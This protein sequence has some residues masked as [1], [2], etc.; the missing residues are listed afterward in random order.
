MNSYFASVEQQAN[1]FLRERVIGVCAYNNPASTIIASS[2]EAKRKGIKTGTKVWEAKKIDPQIILVENEP[3]KYQSTTESIF[4]ILKEY[5]D[6][7]E[8][9]SIDEA[10]LDLTGWVKD[11]DEAYE[12]AKKIQKRILLEVGEWLYSSVGIST[13]KFLAKFAGDIAPKKGILILEDDKKVSKIVQ[14]RNL[15]DAWGIGVRMEERLNSLGIYNL[16]ELKKTSPDL[17]RRK[18]GRSGYYFYCNLNGIEIDKIKRIKEAPK[19][20]GHSFVLPQTTADLKYLKSVF[21][22]LCEKTGRRLR[23]LDKEAQGISVSLTYD[24]AGAVSKSFKTQDKM[25]T[26]KEIFKEVEKY[27][28]KIPLLMQTRGVAV[29]VTRLSELTN[30]M[31]FFENNLSGKDLSKA[32]DKINNKYGE[33]SVIAGEM[34]GMDDVA[35]NRIGFRKVAD[36]NLNA[37]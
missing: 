34:F 30:Q 35:R 7:F 18:L 11:F 22:K 16:G 37:E 32:M 17:L 1:P 21:Y 24:K 20:I 8:P 9:Y 10:F 19:S 3:A 28:N 31:S 29:S 26:T 15:R 13:T 5:T 6:T 33:Y 14:G 12:L 27:L 23:N 25:F 2:I 4:K 36:L